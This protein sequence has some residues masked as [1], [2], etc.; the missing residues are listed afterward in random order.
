MAGK[1]T[2][3]RLILGFLKPL[4]GSIK[5]FGKSPQDA[6]HMIGYVPQAM[7]S[8]R[9]FPISVMEMVLMGRLRWKI[10]FKTF[11]P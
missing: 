11:S 7:E 2:L 4:S 1:T 9:D 8:D 6:R 10:G 5:V 3:V